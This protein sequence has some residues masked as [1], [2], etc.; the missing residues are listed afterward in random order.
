MKN[1][2]IVTGAS[3]GLGKRFVSHLCEGAGGHL[4]EIWTIARNEEELQRLAEAHPNSFVRVIP[5]DLTDRTSFD[6]LESFLEEDYCIQWLV[7]CAGFGTFGDFASQNRTQLSTMVQLNCGAVVEMCSLALGHMTA[8][9]RI[10]NIASIAGAIPQ[11]YLAVYSATKA[12]VLE[13]S[14]MLDFELRGTGI[15]VLA[16]CPKFMQTRFLDK[17]GD[18]DVAQAMCR[19][20]FNDVDAVVRRSLRCALLGIPVLIPS[21]DMQVAAFAA[22]HLPRRALFALERLVFATN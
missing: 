1:I 7:N 10:I 9:S 13:L 21:I 2:A 20:G 17:P 15:H 16:V 14:R 18:A 3:S 11:P 19:I 5:L 12:F 6:E 4:D 22:K 8:G